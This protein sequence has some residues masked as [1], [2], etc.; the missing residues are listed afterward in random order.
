MASVKYKCEDSVMKN[1]KNSNAV[2]PWLAWLVGERACS[3]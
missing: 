2:N 1:E 3:Y